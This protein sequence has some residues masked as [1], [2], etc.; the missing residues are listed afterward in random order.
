[1]RS[2]RLK[3]PWTWPASGRR[4]STSSWASASMARSMPVKRPAGLRAKLQ[5]GQFLRPQPHAVGDVVLGDDEVLAEIVPPAD[6]DV[7]VGVAGI[8]VV[9]RDPIQPGAQIPLHLPHHVAGEGTQ[10][11]EV[12]AVLRGDDEAEL[13]AVLSASLDERL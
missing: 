5:G 9:D 2:D 1:M 4:S 7:A 10:I 11:R 13:V 8:E 12:I 6:D 3:S